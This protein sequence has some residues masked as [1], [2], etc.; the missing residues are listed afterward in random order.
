MRFALPSLYPNI[1]LIVLTVLTT[2]YDFYV[3]CD[4]RI[5]NT[6]TVV[7]LFYYCSTIH[8]IVGGHTHCKCSINSCLRT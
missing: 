6:T 4:W 8:K 1:I 2:C 5:F 3:V 7:L